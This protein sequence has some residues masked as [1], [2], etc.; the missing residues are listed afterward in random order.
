[1]NRRRKLPARF[2][3]IVMPFLLS[4]LM[5]CLVSL[6]ATM[7]S[8]GL[9]PELISLWPGSWALSWLIAFPVTLLV[10]PVVR[11]LTSALVDPGGTVAT[12]R[13]GLEPRATHRSASD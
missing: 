13:Q 3:P 12:P 10:L 4:L 9:T 8:V 6:V 5:T 1:V 11:R 7:R 2:G